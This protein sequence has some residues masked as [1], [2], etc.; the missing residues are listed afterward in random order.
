MLHGKY[1]IHAV[2]GRRCFHPPEFAR[3]EREFPSYARARTWER[4]HLGRL[5]LR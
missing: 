3:E 5:L 4:T 2:E 1:A